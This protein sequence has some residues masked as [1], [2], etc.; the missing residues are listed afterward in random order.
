ME[1]SWKHDI[2][3]VIL[4][5]N[6]ECIFLEKLYGQEFS[7]VIIIPCSQPDI[8]WLRLAV[9]YTT[10]RQYQH[11]EVRPVISMLGVEC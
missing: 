11:V 5:H 9:K 10:F 6:E 2:Y 1:L 8:W 3:I 7:N 4:Q